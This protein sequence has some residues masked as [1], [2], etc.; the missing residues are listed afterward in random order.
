MG[1][2]FDEDQ[3]EFLQALSPRSESFFYGSRRS[4]SDE[5]R[6]REVTDEEEGQGNS[7]EDPNKEVLLLV[8]IQFGDKAKKEL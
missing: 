1:R 7:G 3:R 4:S 5:G 6:L 8:L 2:Q